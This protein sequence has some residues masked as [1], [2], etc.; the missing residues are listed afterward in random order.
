MALGG[1]RGE[2]ASCAGEHGDQDIIS[3]V[4]AVEMLDEER[5]VFWEKSVSGLG[6]VDGDDGDVASHIDCYAF[7]GSHYGY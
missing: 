3:L 6:T 7:L 4:Y 5:I 1:L 2:V